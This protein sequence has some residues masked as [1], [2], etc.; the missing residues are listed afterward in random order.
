[1]S[2]YKHTSFYCPWLNC[3]FWILY[4]FYKWRVCSNPVL[5]K[6]FDAIFPTTFAYFCLCVT[7]WYILQYF[8]LFYYYCYGDLQSVIMSH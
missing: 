4:V 2:Y 7:F 6:S 5:S 1:M 8:K 3:A